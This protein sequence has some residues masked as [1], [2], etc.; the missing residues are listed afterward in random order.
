MKHNVFSS[1]LFNFPFVFS[2]TGG[3]LRE[4]LGWLFFKGSAI[5]MFGAPKFCQVPINFRWMRS[6]EQHPKKKE[7]FICPWRMG[8][9]HLGMIQIPRCIIHILDGWNLNSSV[10]HVYIHVYH[11]SDYLQPVFYMPFTGTITSNRALLPRQLAFGPGSSV[12]EAQKCQ[13]ISQ[14][15]GNIQE[16]RELVL[17]CDYWTKTSWY[18]TMYSF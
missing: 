11:L 7:G 8:V 16:Y 6:L 2:L 17:N 4:G 9:Y 10:W 5:P 12:P 3:G 15:P 14:A 18:W 1:Q 13:N